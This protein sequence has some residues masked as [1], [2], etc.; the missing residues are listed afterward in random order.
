[1]FICN[2]SLHRNQRHFQDGLPLITLNN[3]AQPSFSAGN[4]T[5]NDRLQSKPS[6]QQEGV[7][8]ALCPQSMMTPKEDGSRT[9]ASL[10]E[11]TREAKDIEFENLIPAHGLRKPFVQREGAYTALCPEPMMAPEG[12]GSRT[13]TSTVEDGDVEYV[14]QIPNPEYVNQIPTPEYVNA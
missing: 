5:K 11:S 8:T 2:L 7:Y 13:Y 9:Y 12:E 10:D 4:E 14:N 1:M 3:C 6:V